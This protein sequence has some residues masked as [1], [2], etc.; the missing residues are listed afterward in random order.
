MYSPDEGESWFGPY[1]ISAG[2]VNAS[3]QD[4]LN[5]LSAAFINED[6]IVLSVYVYHDH[7]IYSSI[8]EGDRIRILNYYLLWGADGYED[9]DTVFEAVK[10][11]GKDEWLEG[12]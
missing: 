7:D 8:V 6:E 5:N 1:V 12:E 2:D 4:Y 3:E 11:I 10:K 9:V